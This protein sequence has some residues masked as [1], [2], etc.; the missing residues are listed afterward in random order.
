[1]MI[2][3]WERKRERFLLRSASSRF[4][5]LTCALSDLPRRT[6]VEVVASGM[7]SWGSRGRRF[8]SGRPD[9]FRTLVPRIGNET[10][11]IVPT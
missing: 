8:K 2:R 3:G 5:L 9:D 11:M 10:A 1:M 4:Y 6:S 7:H